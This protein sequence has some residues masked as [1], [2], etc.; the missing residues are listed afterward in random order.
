[1]IKALIFDLGNVILQLH[2]EKDWEQ[3]I[4]APLFQAEAYNQLIQEGFF[5]NFEC[6][7]ISEITFIKTLLSICSQ[8]INEQQLVDAWNAK[9][10]Y[11]PEG[12]IEALELLKWRYRIFLL[13]NTNSI[14]QKYFIGLLQKR[15]GEN[16]FDDL[17]EKC[18]YS[19][20]IKMRKPNREIYEFILDKI[21][22]SATECIFFDDNASNLSYPKSMAMET[23]LIKSS[24]QI[25]EFVE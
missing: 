9:I 1:M 19:H 18:F 6:G 2:D 3:R 21:Q 16:I 8:N 14:H 5:E 20:E 23:I 4:F 24:V 22:L 25:Q 17:F 11:F 13:S 7:L 10:D 12:N 15:Y